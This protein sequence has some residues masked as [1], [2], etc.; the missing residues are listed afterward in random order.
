MNSLHVGTNLAVDWLLSKAEP[1]YLLITRYADP[2]LA[3]RVRVFDPA[4]HHFNPLIGITPERAADIADIIYASDP[5]GETTLTVRNGKRALAKMLANTTRLDRLTGDRKDP[6]EAEALAAVDALLFF[7]TL[8][9]ILCTGKQFDFSGSVVAKIDP[10][11]LGPKQSLALTLLLIGQHKGQIVVPD[12]GRYL[13]PLH[14]SLIDQERLALAVNS[15]AELGDEKD[16]FRLLAETIKD[17][18]GSGCTY[19]DA[20]VLA[21]YRGLVPDYSREDNDYNRFIREAVRG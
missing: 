18:E 20:V 2:F 5:G 1:P 16:P 19:R 13:R 6:A 4:L 14:M 17:K 15:L 3:K 12:G 10:A 9:K 21:G 11:I 7:P 8:R